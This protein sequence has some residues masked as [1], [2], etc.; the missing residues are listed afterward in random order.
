MALLARVVVVTAMLLNLQVEWQ[1][2]GAIFISKASLFLVVLVFTLVVHR[3]VNIGLAGLA[4][5]FV[6]QSNDFALGYPIGKLL[7]SLR[8]LR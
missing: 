1:F 7:M 6:T 4:G 3:P 5:I 2:L 8:G